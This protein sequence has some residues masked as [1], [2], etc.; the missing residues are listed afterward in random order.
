MRR[1]IPLLALASVAEARPSLVTT[2][3]QSGFVRTGRHAEA[4]RMCDHFA[5]AYPGKARCEHFGKSLEG[6]ELVALVVSADG[7]LTPDRAAARH[8]PVVLVEAG[9]HAGEIEGKD[10]GFLFA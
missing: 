6:R 2:A 3:E 8:R 1:V 9:I 7:A 10:A 5:R 4:V